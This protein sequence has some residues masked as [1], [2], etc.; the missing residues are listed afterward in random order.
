MTTRLP[1]SDSTESPKKNNWALGRVPPGFAKLRFV[2]PVWGVKFTIKIVLVDL[3]TGLCKS[4]MSPQR[5]V[6]ASFLR[7]RDR[8]DLGFQVYATV[9]DI[10]A[11]ETGC[12]GVHA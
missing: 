3:K 6:D 4:V 8:T 10:V 12:V 5:D 7:P 9:A 11:R 2:R 1:D